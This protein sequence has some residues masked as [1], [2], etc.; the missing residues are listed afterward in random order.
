MSRLDEILDRHAGLSLKA[1]TAREAELVDE[2]WLVRCR[3]REA[4]TAEAERRWAHSRSGPQVYFFQLET[5]PVKIGYT[6]TSAV[7]RL[8]AFQTY[9]Y[10]LQILGVIRGDRALERQLHQRFGSA[11]IESTEWFEPTEEILAFIAEHDETGTI[12]ASR[13]APT[14]TETT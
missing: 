8:R 4:E 1:L 9:P 5:G 7:E 10:R 12:V 14:T 11:R 6:G 13:D 2:L 3:M